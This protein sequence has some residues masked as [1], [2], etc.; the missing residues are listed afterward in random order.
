MTSATTQRAA[1][2]RRG[3]HRPAPL[4]PVALG[5]IAGV[6]LDNT[7]P[8][9]PEVIVGVTFAGALLGIV[10]LRSRRH[11]RVTLCAALL[12]SAATGAVRHAV[13]MRYLPDHHIARIVEDEPRIRT[14]CGRVV[15]SPRIVERPR[16][17][18][19]A[20]PTAPRTRFILDIT[21]VDG[22][23]GPIPATGRLS[24]TVKEPM[25]LLQLGDEVRI[26]GRLYRPLPP[27]NPGA[28]DWSL[29]LRRDGVHAALSTDH[30]AAVVTLRRKVA[31]P[32]DTLL[33]A[34]RDRARQY[35][36]DE[37][38]VES[39]PAAGVLSAMVLGRRSQVDQTLNEAFVRTG[40]AHFLA[41]SG[42]HVGWLAL[43]GWWLARMI[44]L[45]NRQCAVLVALLIIAY[46]M[47]AEPRPSIMRAGAIGVLACVGIYRAGV[48]N[49]L[50]W[51]SAA[52]ILLLMLDPT[53]VFRPA[54]Q[55][56]FVAVL[57]IVYLRPIVDAFLTRHIR[58]FQK[59]DAL[60]AAVD[61]AVP[62][63]LTP[64]LPRRRELV[65]NELLRAVRLTFTA[66]VAAWIANVPLASYHFNR[67][68]PFGWL[69]NLVLWIPAFLVT[70]LGFLKV[71]L[72]LVF[73]SSVILT[74]P[75]LQVAINAFLSLVRALAAIPGGLVE[76]ASPSL[77]WVAAI[78][79]MLILRI[80]FPM[81]FDKRAFT[82]LIYIALLL[83]FL[84]PAR[85]AKRDS[86]AL[87]VWIL[88]VGD[89]T[90]IVI[91]LPDSRTMLF[92][93]GTR[94]PFDAST[95]AT[96]FLDHRAIDEIETAFITHAN[97]DHYGAM[98]SI[99][100]KVPIRR[101]IVSDQ[102]DHFVKESGGAARFFRSLRQTGDGMEIVAGP[103]TWR[104]ASGVE[105]EILG[106]I[107]AADG[108]PPSA[109]DSSL[110]LRLTYQ[111]H[112]IL[113]T[114]DQS[115]W[116][117]GHLLARPEIHADALVLPH[118][119]AVAHNTQRFIDRVNPRIAIRS[120]GQRRDM[121]TNGIERLVGTARTYLTTADDGC[122]RL[123][124]K[125]HSLTATPFLHTD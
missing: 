87:N 2:V 12:V 105:F 110:A 30:A 31:G 93:F 88:A 78:Y 14:L 61:A 115:E 45:S 36:L 104:D 43:I 117:L 49:T 17:Q 7:V 64:K 4:L 65:A 52:V 112:S 81:R 58:A 26:T 10:A 101:V 56:S 69:Y 16:D 57:S 29:L 89:G 118:H 44:G 70:A 22:A 124:I 73:P 59:L 41:A 24:V 68:A 53:D 77:L 90:G 82:P 32:V 62:I 120:T 125:N 21:S 20:Y 97:F 92:D 72:A 34:A 91:E 75:L 86:G 6:T 106:P 60:D 50:N 98:P 111:G 114:G 1:S 108:R 13:R 3:N 121:T 94:S 35:L 107:A 100:R 74:G 46:T 103:K 71:L 83:W 63:P 18:A 33:H 19:V 79:T 39:D 8:L 85:W 38:V 80:R 84:I 96:A 116:G 5:L 102:F 109:N 9:S 11:A 48:T 99:Q 55:F 113:L 76:G 51:L 122:I 66:S 27:A 67:F 47:L 42:L 54:F 25:P 37:C 123:R 40:A 23:A 119:G 28:Y 95:T 15:T